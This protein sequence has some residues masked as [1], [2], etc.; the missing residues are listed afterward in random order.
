MM[1]KLLQISRLPQGGGLALSAS[2]NGKRK[3]QLWIP[4]LHPRRK[5]FK[6]RQLI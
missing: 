4:L 3:R 1:G 5:P 6:M 2:A